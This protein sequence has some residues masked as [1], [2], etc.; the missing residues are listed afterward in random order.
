MAFA[1]VAHA[2][3]HGRDLPLDR[4]S[5]LSL[6]GA[7]LLDNLGVPSCP[8]CVAAWRRRSWCMDLRDVQADRSARPLAQVGIGHA[9]KGAVP[10]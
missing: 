1:Y 3:G 8:L 6:M 10:E 4:T 5:P 2:G 7:C 9:N